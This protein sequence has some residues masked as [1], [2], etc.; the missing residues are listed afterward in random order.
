MVE[1]IAN[2]EIDRQIIMCPGYEMT[3]GDFIQFYEMNN[4]TLFKTIT[5]NKD[6]KP[7]NIRYNINW[8]GIKQTPYERMFSI[9]FSEA[10]PRY[11]LDESVRVFLNG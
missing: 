7:V 5:K 9:A 6:F 10:M 11:A 2:K 3:L 8:Y 4:G 1:K